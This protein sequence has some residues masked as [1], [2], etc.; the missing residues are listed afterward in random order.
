MRYCAA[1]FAAAFGLLPLNAAE[2]SYFR[3]IRPVLQRQCQGCHQPNLKSSNL[4]LTSY[5]GLVAGGKHGPG[6][7]VIVKY[8]SGEMKPQ[9]P[10]GQPALAAAMID[11]VR[12][13]IAAGARDDTPAAERETGSL[14]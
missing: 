11:L 8:L 9:M 13:W 1:A 7:S 2:P 4:D 5:E 10:L 14:E 12:S 3:E 6:L